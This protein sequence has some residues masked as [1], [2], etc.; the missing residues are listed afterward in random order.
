[1]I[2]LSSYGLEESIGLHVILSNVMWWI[3][4]ILVIIA[5]RNRRI[6]NIGDAPWTFLFLAFFFFGIREL[7]HLSKEPLIGSIRYIFGIWS[8]IFMTTALFFIFLILCHG[9]RITGVIIYIPYALALIF[10]VIWSYL[11]ISDPGNLKSAMGAIENITWIIGSLVTIY[12]AYMLG[13]RTTGDFVKVFMFFQFSAYLALT[14]KFLGLI[15]TQGFTV[16]YSIREIIETLFGLFAIISMYI[17]TRM[18]RKLSKQL[19]GTYDNKS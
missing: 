17:L 7:G 12:T 10:P 13:T 1:M 16:S 9:R 3:S 2:D 18:L 8:A 15:E 6:W 14:W 5:F 19:H 4:L 11:Y